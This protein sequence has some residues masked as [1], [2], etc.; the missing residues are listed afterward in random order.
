MYGASPN[1]T[2]NVI[3][4]ISV[5]MRCKKVRMQRQGTGSQP[6]GLAQCNLIERS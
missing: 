2:R 1:L 3:R 6:L 4:L 5:E